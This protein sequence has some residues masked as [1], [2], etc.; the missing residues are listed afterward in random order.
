LI[1]LTTHA[2]KQ[3]AQPSLSSKHTNCD[4]FRLIVNE[5]LTLKVPLNIEEDIETAVKFFND[6]MQWAGWK[7]TPERT[8]TPKAKNCPILIKQKIEG[9]RRL[10]RNWQ[11]LLTV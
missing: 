11:R 1:T 5:R 7:A 3:E 2:H 10:C 9:K 8:A 4:Q 6:T